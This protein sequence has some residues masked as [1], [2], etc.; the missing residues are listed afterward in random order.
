MMFRFRSG[1]SDLAVYREH[2]PK[3]REDPD[4]ND[5]I[6][7]YQN[8]IDG[9]EGLKIE[10]LLATKGTN[11]RWLERCHSF[12]QW[13]FPIQEPGLNPDAQV[14]MKHEIATFKNNQLMLQRAWRCFNVMVQFYG[15]SVSVIDVKNGVRVE[16]P[17]S[18]HYVSNGRASLPWRPVPKPAVA[19]HFERLADP[20]V[21]ESLYYNLTTSSHNYLRITRI[22][23]FL[24]ELGMEDVKISWLT[25]F[26]Q[27]VAITRALRSCG[28]SLEEYWSGT[29]Y[30]DNDRQAFGEWMARLTP[31]TNFWGPS[32]PAGGAEPVAASSAADAAVAPTSALH[33]EESS[34]GSQGE[35]VLA[36]VPNSGPT[37]S[38]GDEEDV[39]LGQLVDGP[40]AG[41][42]EFSEERK[43]KV[44]D[45]EADLKLL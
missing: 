35:E 11:Y 20:K 17:D 4:A 42:K 2:Y 3:K 33:R 25:F 27:E 15:M 1:A 12:V 32:L 44:R 10:E 24:G 14:L 28:S 5:N 43:R 34:Q 8:K 39:P 37:A 23:K 16:A 31:K 22:L 7:F 21:Q 38:E 6:K 26:A 36:A 18:S 41:L 13:I 45:E 19:F 9:P 30:N 40:L 29:I